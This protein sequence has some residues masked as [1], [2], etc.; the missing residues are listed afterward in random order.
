MGNRYDPAHT[1]CVLF[2]PAQKVLYVACINGNPT[3]ENKGS[4]L[5]KLGQNGKVI[6]LKFTENLNSTKGMGIMGNKLYVT[7]MT[8][9]AEIA[10]AT[11]KIL[12][13]YPLEGAKFPDDI[14][15]DTQKGGIVYVSDS[16]DSKVWVLTN[17]KA[18]LV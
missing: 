17:G 8:Q 14:A 5:A 6:Q 7:E 3:L 9:V 10:L 13:R 4:Y 16:N 1:R 15:I 2:D 18:T 12:N 11:G